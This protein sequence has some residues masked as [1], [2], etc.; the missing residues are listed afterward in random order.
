[1]RKKSILSFVVGLLFVCTINAKS[2]NKLWCLKATQPLNIESLASQFRYGYTKETPI[3]TNMTSPFVE[4]VTY[5]QSHCNILCNTSSVCDM[6]TYYNNYTCQLYSYNIINIS[7]IAMKV[8]NDSWATCLMSNIESMSEMVG[9]RVATSLGITYKAYCALSYNTL[10]DNV[11][12][13]PPEPPFSPSNLSTCWQACMNMN[14]CSHVVFQ[15]KYKEMN[16]TACWL[17]TNF[18]RGRYGMG[19][20]DYMTD[21]S[22]FKTTQEYLT[23]GI[24]SSYEFVYIPENTKNSHTHNIRIHITDEFFIFWLFS[25]IYYIL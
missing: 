11:Q 4:I 25:I 5:H 2:T 18:K 7:S 22:C 14:K 10:G 6:F 21:A 16:V 19:D 13:V 1:M 17:K 9:K 15:S 8:T 24:D 20:I 12:D 23:V 3:T